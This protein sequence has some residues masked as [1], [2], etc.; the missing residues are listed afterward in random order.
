MSIQKHIRLIELYCTICH[1]YDSALFDEAQRQSNNFCP[2]FTDEECI[3]IYIWGIIEQKYTVKAIY[4]FIKNYYY[5]WF[6]DL[7]SYTAFNKRTCY[8]SDAFR[9]LADLLTN[10]LPLDRR[11]K[12]HLIDSMPVIV[13]NNKR[14]SSAKVAS[15]I[16]DKG[17]CGSKNMYYYGVKLHVLGQYKKGTLPTPTNICITKASE[18]DL[19][20]AKR[21]LDDIRGIELY[22]DKA[23]KDGEWESYINKEQDIEVYTPIKHEKG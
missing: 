9:K 22:A 20:V 21:I 11:A 12:A 6:P 5:D 23:Y 7:P 19:S 18:S 2:K 15:D 1:Y 3:T 13:A 14:S 8:L 16:C 10:C 4:D 17:Y